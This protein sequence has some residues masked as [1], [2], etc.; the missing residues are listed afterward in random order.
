MWT[1]LSRNLGNFP[2]V[3]IFKNSSELNRQTFYNHFSKY[4]GNQN[5][6]FQIHAIIH[7]FPWTRAI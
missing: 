4:F 1:K 6:N 2:S 3:F 5:T 7:P